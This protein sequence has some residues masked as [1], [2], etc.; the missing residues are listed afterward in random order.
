MSDYR[1]CAELY[2]NTGKAGMQRGA[3]T[4]EAAL[5]LPVL[6]CAFLS[7]LF[8]VKA[9]Y[10]YELVNHALNETASEI[11]SAAYIY[12]VSGLRDLHD[13]V[14]NG[15][16]DKSDVFKNQIGSVFDIFDSL[17]NA[18]AEMGQGLTGIADS[19][20]LL[21]DAGNNFNSLVDSTAA[22][23]PLEEL[24]SIAC[25]IASGAF[26]DAKTQLFT[27]VLKLTMKKYLIT[28]SIPDI[29]K[30]MR[31]LNVEDG[32]GGMDFSESS[33]L[34]DREE[35]I[36]IVVHYKIHLP[37]PIQFI[38]AVN[39]TQRAKVKAWLGGD[40]STGVLD[41]VQSE[42]DLWSLNNFQRG[43]KIR[44]LFGANLPTNFPVIA[45][46]S[47]GRAVM[48]KSM[49]L[50][51]DSYQTGDNAEKLLNGYI[52]G[53]AGFKGMEK[54]WGSSN[55]V[56]HNSDITSRE[57]LLVIPENKLTDVNERLLV[58][59]AEKAKSKG[60]NLTVKRYGTKSTQNNIQTDTG[61]GSEESG[62][63]SDVSEP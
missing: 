14:R 40:E 2:G 54:P 58:L 29:D 56:I 12:H 45:K 7:I 11:A 36:D 20:E 21:R 43:L 32:Y 38:P 55:I 47:N 42:D 48:I 28:D 10:T 63:Q 5:V 61:Q 37:L 49:D 25:Y 26:D 8:I 62:V 57:L 60:I 41:A 30:R 4:V 22:S 23:D 33:F 13:T 52:S 31:L 15:I 50:T 18:K 16:N 35:N 24:K 3:L 9:I 39:I 27:P 6:L 1:K 17:K 46:F 51:A 44:N 53:L 19:A 59:M 34:A